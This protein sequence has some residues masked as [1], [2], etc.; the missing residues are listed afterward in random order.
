MFFRITIRFSGEMRRVV[1]REASEHV[2]G[3]V[4]GFE[5]GIFFVTGVLCSFFSPPSATRGL[6]TVPTFCI[7]WAVIDNYGFIVTKLL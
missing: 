2:L 4:W 3:L 6:C 5:E 7:N 1:L